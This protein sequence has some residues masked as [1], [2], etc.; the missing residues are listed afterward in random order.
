LALA[1]PA[2]RAADGVLAFET[3]DWRF[4]SPAVLG[5]QADL[6]LAS[7]QIQLCT[8]ELKRLLHYRPR[9]VERFTWRWIIDGG[10]ISYAFAT[11]VETHVDE[12]WRLVD[13][14][15]RSFKESIV[16]RGA[17][18]GPHEETHVLTW[19][20]WRMAWPNEGFA[21]FTDWLYHSAS[22]RY[23]DEPLRLPYECGETGWSFGQEHHPYSDLRRFAV[24]NEMYNT[25]ACFWVE[26][27]R[28]GG[29][30]ALRRILLR[31]RAYRAATPGELVVNHVN[32]VLGED[33]RPIA[34]RYG[35]T[36]SDLAAAG[37]PPPD[38]PP[39]ALVL[40][41]PRPTPS[42]PSAARQLATSLSVARSDT[43]D[44]VGAAT[45]RCSA[46]A[47]KLALRVVVR[48]FERGRA[49]C[50]WHVPRTTRGRTLRATTTVV[51]LGVSGSKTYTARIR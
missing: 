27:Y 43:G 14:V 39:P 13:P 24:T 22:W 29:F 17:C 47:G 40:T 20:S 7:R 45:V 33:L 42:R 15:T 25:A 2:S 50:A 11:G 41:A 16:A 36:D 5:S 32:P 8:D 31:L 9:N 4:E 12:S 1:A 28:R 21:T 44:A 3:E 23:G 18:F 48:R 26:V 37:A 6:E 38:P 51:Y 30:P 19:E 34:K 10:H 35:F 46:R 49:T